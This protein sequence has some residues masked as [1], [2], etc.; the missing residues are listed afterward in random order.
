MSLLCQVVTDYRILSKQKTTTYSR[1]QYTAETTDMVSLSP[2]IEETLYE[3]EQF[4]LQVSTML[5]SPNS[6]FKYQCTA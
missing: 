2:K 6:S 1:L 3:I 4:Y 5:W